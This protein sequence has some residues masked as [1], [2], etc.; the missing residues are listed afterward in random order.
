LFNDGIGVVVFVVILELAGGRAIT[1]GGVATLFAR[2]A[3]GG[4][5]T[6]IP[7]RC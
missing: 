7:W 3:L 2:E 5:S 4:A 1:A 6:P